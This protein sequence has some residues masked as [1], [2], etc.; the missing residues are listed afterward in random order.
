MPL[1][2]E[3]QIRHDLETKMRSTPEFEYAFYD[4]YERL[5]AQV[6][7]RVAIRLRTAS[8]PKEK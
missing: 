5:C 6:Y 8:K 1:A 7:C 3:Q 4:K 2:I